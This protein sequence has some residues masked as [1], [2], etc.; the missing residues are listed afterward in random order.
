M[1]L[2][3][4][5]DQGTIK[6]RRGRNLGRPQHVAGDTGCSSRPARA[7]LRRRGVGPVIPRKV[8]EQR[9]GL[10]D[11]TANREHNVV[12]RSIN[13]LKMHRAIATR[14]EKLEVSYHALLTIT[15]LLL[16]LSLCRQ[17]WPHIL[18]LPDGGH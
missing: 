12:E 9:D 17:D 14:Y 1:A 7:A 10:F 6:Y 15:C 13:R 5:L 2:P 11:Y 16:W 18:G 3:T 8:T 4:L